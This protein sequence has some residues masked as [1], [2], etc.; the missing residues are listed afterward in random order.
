MSFRSRLIGA[1]RPEPPAR[2][3]RGA[4][5][6]SED[7]LEILRS[8]RRI[9]IKSRRIVQELFS[10][11]YHAVFKGTGIEFSEVREYVPGDDVRSIDWNVTART[12]RPFVKQYHEERERSVVF[13]VDRSGSTRF[14]SGIR[15]VAWIAAETTALLALSAASNQDK[16]GL[17]LFSDRLERWVPPRKGRSHILRIVREVL[18]HQSVGSRTRLAEALERAS[19]T[20]RRRSLIF[21]ISDFLQDEEYDGALAIAARKHEVVPLVLLDPREEDL[22]SI[23]LIETRDLET[24]ER[25]LTDSSDPAVR[26]AFAQAVKAR[27]DR[28]GA[29]FRRAG[30]EGV[31]LRTDRDIVAPL[32]VYF[33]KRE[34]WRAAG[35]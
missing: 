2:P 25:K 20:L 9:E 24:G 27:R 8:V 19:R 15:S 30:V 12:D 34:R 22:P 13:L 14:G 18:F 3:R 1:G 35:R 11:S 29:I 5:Q 26:Q 4:R 33:R 6:E 7:A 17:L 31:E 10:G 23:G 32:M 16:V 28:R 21:L